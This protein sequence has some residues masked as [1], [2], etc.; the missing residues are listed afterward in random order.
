MIGLSIIIPCLNEEGNIRKCIERIPKMPYSA[1]VI[2][3]DDGSKDKTSQ[4]ARNTKNP[5]LKKIKVVSYKNNRGKGYAFRKGLEHA[6]GQVV[7]I[8]DADMT[9]PPEEIPLIT[10]PIFAGKADF[11][12]GSRLFYPM[13]KGAMKWLHIPGNRI[14][15][16]IISLIIGKYLT[17]TLCGFKAFKRQLIPVQELKENSWMD[18]ELLIKAKRNNLRIA[19]VPIHYKARKAGLS[20]MRTF[21]H[22]YNMFMMLLKAIQKN[23]A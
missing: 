16:L 5:N 15:A 20:K 10:G 23:E 18:F 11:V 17:D 9:S 14:F 1:E 4:T 21:K 7:I 2:V 3:V 6:E 22:G 19:E 13:E 12:N 8:L